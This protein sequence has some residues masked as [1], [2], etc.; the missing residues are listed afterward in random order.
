MQITRRKKNVIIRKTFKIV[1]ELCIIEIKIHSYTPW[2]GHCFEYAY[3][4]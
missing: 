3:T 2:V 1:H 4:C